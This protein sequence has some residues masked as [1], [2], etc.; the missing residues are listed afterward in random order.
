MVYVFGQIF[1]V[2]YLLVDSFYYFVNLCN[3]TKDERLINMTT[4]WVIKGV[5]RRTDV[6][7]NFYT[8]ILKR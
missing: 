1:W 4:H 3:S 2:D 7:N 8:M 6:I 5:T